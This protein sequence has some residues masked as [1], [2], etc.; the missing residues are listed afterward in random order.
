VISPHIPTE[1]PYAPEIAELL[2]ITNLRINFTKLQTLGDEL[3]D[4]RPEIDEKYW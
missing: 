3:F 2:K 1:D 4:Y